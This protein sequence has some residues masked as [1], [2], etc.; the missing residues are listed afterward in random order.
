MEDLLGFG[1]STDKIIEAV[2]KAVGAIYRPYGMRREADAEAYRLLTLE[3]AKAEAK[4][5]ELDRRLPIGSEYRTRLV[6]ADTTA[7]LEER[8]RQRQASEALRQQHNIDSVVQAAI[9]E[10]TSTDSEEEIDLDWLNSFFDLAKDVSVEQ[11]QVIWGKV[12]AK[13]IGRPGS[14]TIRSLETLK[15][16]TRREAVTFS[17][18]CKLASK[19]MGGDKR[20]ILTGWVTGGVWRNLF[21]ASRKTLKLDRFGVGFLEI[22]NLADIG[23]LY[24][25][26]LFLGPLRKGNEVDVELPASRLIIKARKGKIQLTNVQ[27]TP[28]GSELAVLVPPEESPE[29]ISALREMLSDMFVV[30]NG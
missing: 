19:F 11:M 28:T 10:G 8:I 24:E 16:M 1:K 3:R 13:E 7:Q 22:K 18:A 26:E 27:F 2:S 5:E 17:S 6:R 21:G 20:M 4:A 14:F 23:L 25:E 9:D 29:Y 15:R 12:L 30:A